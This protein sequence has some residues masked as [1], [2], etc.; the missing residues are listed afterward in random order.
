MI[1]VEDQSI[2]VYLVRPCWNAWHYDPRGIAPMGWLDSLHVMYV[3][4]VSDHLL[5]CVGIA[6]AGHV[7]RQ[8]TLV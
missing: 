5:C 6:V 1:A 4:N 7:A 3:T 8:R 2:Q